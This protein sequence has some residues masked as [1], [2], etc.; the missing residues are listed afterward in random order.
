MFKKVLQG[1]NQ[2]KV[3]IF[4]LFLLCSFLAWFI[5]NLSETYESRSDFV[6]NYRNL[7]DTLLLGKNSDEHLEVK[8]RTSGFQFLYY[9]FFKKRIDINVSQANYQNGRYVLSED[10][11]KRQID[12]QL[13]QNI[14]LLDVDQNQLVLDLYQVASKKIPIVPNMDLQLEQNYILDGKVIMVP[15]SV[16]VKGPGSEIDTIKEIMTAPIRLVNVSDSFERE[17]SLVFP[18][19]LENS[20]FSDAR[21][22]VSG[23]VAKFSEKVF[24]VPVQVLNIPD[25]YQVKTFPSSITVLCKASIDRLKNISASDFNVEADYAKSKGSNNTLFLVISKR[26]ENVYD[27]RLQENSVNFVLEQQ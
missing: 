2:K 8:L 4:S 7:P 9:N 22:S 17:A 25:G 3:K 14:S 15:D 20:V 24:D 26:P 21:V 13:S 16:T 1:L 11:L 12:Q 23:K 10:N 5:S 27:V 6:L 19:G 18:K